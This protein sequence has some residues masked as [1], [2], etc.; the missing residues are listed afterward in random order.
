MYLMSNVYFRGKNASRQEGPTRKQDE[1]L[2]LS[3]R[4]QTVHFK[5][6]SEQ[7]SIRLEKK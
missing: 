4:E 7:S 3:L 6:N 5:F 1:N 2:S